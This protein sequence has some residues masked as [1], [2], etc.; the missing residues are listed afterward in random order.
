VVWGSFVSRLSNHFLYSEQVDMVNASRYLAV[1]KQG[2][3]KGARGTLWIMKILVPVSLATFL[4][5]ASGLLDRCDHLL[6][7]VM[8][9]FQ[10]PATAALPLLAGLLTGIYGAIAAMSVLEFS[11]TESILM[12]V[13]LLISHALPQESLVQARSGMSFGRATLVRLAASI[14]I[15]LIVAQILP[16]DDK[17]RM[18]VAAVAQGPTSLGSLLASWFWD[19][20]RLGLKIL[21]IITAMMTLLAWLQAINCI[22]ALARAL[23]PFLRLM[24][25]SRPVGILWLTA[26]V[27]GL[28][29]GAAVIVEETRNGHFDAADMRRLHLSIGINHAVLEDPLLFLA[30]GLPAF[31]LWGP[32]LAAA[33]LV[34]Y[35]D[36]LWCRVRTRPRPR[37]ALQAIGKTPRG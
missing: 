1:F 34:V 13:F 31:W 29:Y 3:R 30:M 33:I 18:A 32:R 25:L 5:D 20:A 28:S 15:T 11:M 37:A 35:F 7:P 10:L 19:T 23:A 8:A 21:V 26:A 24:G 2:L 12:A 22:P 4:I 16:A 6:A 9:L 14:L 36:R 27:F 17:T